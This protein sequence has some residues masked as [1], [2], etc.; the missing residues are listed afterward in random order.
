MKF[1]EN[2]EYE[3]LTPNGW[4]NFSGIKKI[5][6]EN[7]IKMS[8]NDDTILECSLNHKIKLL[9][10]KFHPA[11][12]IKLNDITSTKKIVNDIKVINETVDLYDLIDV[13]LN[14]EYIANDIV[15]HNCAFIESIDTIWAASQQTLATGGKAIV[16]STPNGMGNFFHKTWVDAEAK[17]NKFNPI[18]LHWRLHPDRD[19]EWR[20][21]Q[22]KIL[23]EKLAA[24]ECLGGNSIVTIQTTDG[25]IIDITLDNL[26]NKVDNNKYKILT[27][28]GFKNFLGITKR[29]KLEYLK[30][31]LSNGTD[32]IC[33]LNHVF[34]V[35]EKEV[36]AAK[37]NIFDTI[38][39]ISGN[40]ISILDIQY[41]NDNI[42]LFD[43]IDVGEE[44]L[45]IVNGVV[46]HNCEADFISSG[47]TAIPPE[48]I[49]YYSD[50]FVKDPIEKRGID[51]NLW[52]WQYPDYTRSY[53][54]SA[55]VAR[56]DGRDFSG[57]QVLDVE[58]LE[59]VAEYKGKIGTTEFGNLCVSIATEYNNAL[60]VIENANVGWASIQ[61]A[62]DRG[63]ANLFYSSKDLNIVD[64]QVSL[65]KRIDLKDKSQLI[66]GFT[67]SARTRPL[68]ISKMDT[69]LR[70]KLISMRSK[71][72][73]DELFTFIWRGPK[74]EAMSGYNDD[75]V[76]SYSIGLWVRDTAMRLRDEGIALQ[77]TSIS[78]IHRVSAPIMRPGQDHVNK[79]WSVDIKGQK[80]DL[81]WLI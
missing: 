41:F 11:Q 28:H 80:E 36:I 44:N 37:L 76:M 17:L 67:T 14:W 71:R 50:S 3:V 1:K 8:F 30:L 29:E 10:G 69:Y 46:S 73:I 31:Y 79:N 74:A 38:D 72:L 25:E 49:Q 77:K 48:I 22:T 64:T 23:G 9:D 12:H 13:E 62:I 59:Q 78:N 63:Y 39:S 55:D 70:E 21:Q 27:P 53:I 60:L 43:I 5:T 45:F 57:I 26:Y 32:L 54:V 16:L 66:P 81:T 56:G 65:N 40:L 58:T 51:S 4:S 34:I 42:E 52:V 19:D 18:R 7:Y 75:L 47:N 2:N 20:E 15:N 35:N 24:Q 33:S 6:K 68:I 61:V